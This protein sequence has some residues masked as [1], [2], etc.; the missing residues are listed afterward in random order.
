[1]SHT[2]MDLVRALGLTKVARIDALTDRR[3][4]YDCV[5]LG[6]Q[7]VRI[8]ALIELITKTPGLLPPRSGHIGNWEPIAQGRAGAMDFNK[9]ICAGSLGYPMIYAFTQTEAEVADRRF[10]D[11]VYLPGSLIR[12]GVRHELRLH[13]FDGQTFVPRSRE[14]A[15]FC[16][17]VQAEVDGGLV[18]L[19]ELH[20]ECLRRLPGFRFDLEARLIVENAHRVRVMLKALLE[21]ASRRD[22]PRRA[23]QDLISHAATTAGVVTRCDTRR[24]GQGYFVD[25]Q[26]FASTEELVE[27]L[28]VPFFAVTDPRRVLSK[29]GALPPLVPVMS[30]LL[31]GI[32]SAIFGADYPD[33]GMPHGP[34]TAHFHWSAR[35]MG[36]YPPWRNGYFIEKSTAKSLSRICQTLVETCGEAPLLMLLLP[37]AVFMLCP[38]SAHPMDVELVGQLVSDTSVA[39]FETVEELTRKWL[40]TNATAL[41]PYF[42]SRFRAGSGVLPQ[43]DIPPASDPIEPQGF[44]SLSFKHAC[45]IVGT[46][47]DAMTPTRSA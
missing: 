25:D 29:I 6:M 33:G 28:L 10:G 43:A 16:P 7:D 36:G 13:T 23:F 38:A 32:F 21:E 47:I 19:V 27:A 1:M 22:N 44:R 46:L 15:R 3:I 8:G 24:S 35:D 9:A 4:P 20:G 41:S 11:W 31:V 42:L 39:A 45:M 17:F 26:F 30:A 40:A 37:A 18:P 12:N 14:T 34:F 2:P 5:H